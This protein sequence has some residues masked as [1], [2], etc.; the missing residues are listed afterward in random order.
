MSLQSASSTLMHGKVMYTLPSPHHT[1]YR[2]LPS[3]SIESGLAVEGRDINQVIIYS[4]PTYFITVCIK[5][6]N[7]CL[8]QVLLTDDH[9]SDINLRSIR[10]LKNI[11]Y[12]T[13]RLLKSFQIEFNW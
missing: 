7:D 2:C 12:I 11:I 5:I 3:I 1:A 9:F 8:S 6:W 4:H 13:G 10:R